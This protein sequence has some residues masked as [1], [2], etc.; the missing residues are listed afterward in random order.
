MKK[1]KQGFTLIELLTVIAIIGILA[2]IIIPSVGAVRKSA[3]KAKTQSMFSQ[4]AVALETF[5]Q[6]YGYYPDPF[7]FPQSEG[8]AFYNLLTG[9][10]SAMNPKQIRYYSFSE[11]SIAKDSPYGYADGT[12]VD[13]F[14]N[15]NIEMA[16]DSDRNGIIES[17]ELNGAPISG[18]KIRS[19]VI[20][21]TTVPDDNKR[22]FEQ[23]TSW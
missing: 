1:N 20:F 19:S 2:G 12:I 4:W 7:N 15:P 17:G 6:D 14:D 10:D 9:G 21:W 5:R 13:A 22:D 23:V 16:V 3:K 8:G 18:T 11:D